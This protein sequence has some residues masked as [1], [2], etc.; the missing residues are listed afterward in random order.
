MTQEE[1][2]RLKVAI[3]GGGP[4]GLGAALE[5]ARLPFV[6]WRLYEKKQQISE[7]GGGISLQPQT[8]RLLEHN[9]AARNIFPGDF[10]RPAGRQRE[11]RRNGRTGELLVAEFNPYDVPR[12]H[13]TCRLVRA[14]LQS[15]LLK[16]VSQTRI[17]VNKKLVGIEHLR[18]SRVNLIFEDGFTDVVDLVIGADG[19][20]SVV[21]KYQFPDFEPRYTGQLV[22]RTIVRKSEARKIHGIPWCPT[23]WKHVS[24]LY[25]FTSPLGDD[26]FEVTVRIRPPRPQRGEEE[27]VSWGWSFDLGTLLHKYDDFCPPVRQ[28]LCLAAGECGTQEFAL[29]S[30]RR[31]PSVVARGNTVL[32]G[33]AAH[34][35]SGY[36]GSG[37]GFALEDVYAL[38]K[39]L[40]W[41]WARQTHLPD[42]LDLHDAIRTPYYKELYR[43]V[44][45]FAA[46]K[47]ELQARRLPV[48]EE[49]KQRVKRISQASISTQWM[50]SYEISKVVEEAVLVADR[51]SLVPRTKSGHG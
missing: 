46:I 18:D 13:Q 9:G 49:I 32:V 8:W 25:V 44:D 19:I 38:A 26:D 15:A 34:P 6:D 29:F 51:K 47:A 27:P 45:S 41:S 12:H 31:L 42:A 35:Q 39:A 10:F 14:K 23:F 40:D 37:A 4:A 43:V 50:Y 21:R 22:Y 28:I 5:L 36:F 33:D 24:G 1:T 48:D 11:Q 17:H 20:R 2:K 7:T 16:G 3:I 30:G